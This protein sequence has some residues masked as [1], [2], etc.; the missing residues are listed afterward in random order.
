V[1]RLPDLQRYARLLDSRFTIPG[2]KIRFGLDPIIGLVP[3]LGDLTSPV[4]TGLLVLEGARLG[5]PKIILARMV[6]NALVDALIGIIPFA[7]IVG[8]V[9]YRANNKN[10]ALLEKHAAPGG[11][12]AR[13]ADYGFVFG[14]MAALVIGMILIVWLAIWLAVKAWQMVTETFGSV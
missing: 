14:M 7:G 8:D 12:A 2:T 13:R 1:I 9:F 11:V 4:F 10:L 3:W 5:I 6:V